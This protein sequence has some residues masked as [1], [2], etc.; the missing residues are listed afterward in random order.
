LSFNAV[1]LFSLFRVSCSSMTTA[2]A[3]IMKTV[4][5]ESPGELTSNVQERALR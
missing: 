1:D 3:L 2:C 4:L 5:E